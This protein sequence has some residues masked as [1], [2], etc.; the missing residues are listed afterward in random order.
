MILEALAL[1]RPVVATNVG[2]VPELIVHERT[3]LLVPPGDVG[4][5]AGALERL[6]C[7]P[8]LGRDLAAA[9]KHLARMFTAKRAL[10]LLERAYHEEPPI[11]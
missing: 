5:F 11:S 8:Q 3:G 1:E 10:P 7:N 9:G 2:G 4:T 6:L